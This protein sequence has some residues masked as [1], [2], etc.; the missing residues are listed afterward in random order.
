MSSAGTAGEPTA[1]EAP[2]G[3]TI[4]ELWVAVDG[5]GPVDL[6]LWDVQP[7]LPRFR[8]VFGRRLTITPRRA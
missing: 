1:I 5:K 6:E 4:D 3:R 8:E 2:A 7:E